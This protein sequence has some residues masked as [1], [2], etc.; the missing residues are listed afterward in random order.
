MPNNTGLIALYA[1][2]QKFTSQSISA[3]VF[4][5]PA[6]HPRGALPMKLVMQEIYYGYKYGIKTWYYHRTN[7]GQADGHNNRQADGCESGAC[8][9]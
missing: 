9:I 8:A 7:D 6:K 2:I 4:H 3:N 5:T 1:I